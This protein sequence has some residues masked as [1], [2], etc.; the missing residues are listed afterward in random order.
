MGHQLFRHVVGGEGIK[1]GAVL[2]E[3]GGNQH[4]IVVAAGVDGELG[5]LY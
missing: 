5:D 3:D 4:Q 2:R 1:D